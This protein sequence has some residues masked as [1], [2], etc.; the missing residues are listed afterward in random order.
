MN[1]WYFVF[2]LMVSSNNGDVYG[3]WL[4]DEENEKRR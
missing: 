1:K 4:I 2:N 3:L